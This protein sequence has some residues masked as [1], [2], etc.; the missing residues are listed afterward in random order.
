VFLCGVFVPLCN[1]P[2]MAILTTRPPAALRAKVMTATLTASGLGGPAMRLL[3]GPVYNAWGNSGVWTMLAGG[4]S[5]GALLF[6]GT[7]LRV[8]AA[9]EAQATPTIA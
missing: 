4:L 3:V 6:A 5:L 7:A 1:A 9:G 8:D 2:I